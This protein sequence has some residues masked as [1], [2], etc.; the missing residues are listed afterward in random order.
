MSLD[1]SFLGFALFIDQPL[2]NCFWILATSHVCHK[3]RKC[4]FQTISLEV[5][6]LFSFGVPVILNL[7]RPQLLLSLRW[8]D[9]CFPELA[10]STVGILVALSWPQKCCFLSHIPKPLWN[11]ISWCPL[12]H[13][14][15]WWSSAFSWL[16]VPGFVAIPWSWHCFQGWGYHL[17]PVFLLSFE[18]LW[19]FSSSMQIWLSQHRWMC[20]KI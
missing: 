10:S 15:L 12:G 11:T 7:A 20:V 1:I 3:N 13:P 18:S 6:S 17:A 4:I 14:C 8:S 2:H 5:F 9:S 19:K 16:L